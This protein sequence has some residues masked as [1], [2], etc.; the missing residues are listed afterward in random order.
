M[1]ACGQQDA[2][3]CYA[4]LHARWRFWIYVQHFDHDT[5]HCPLV[6]CRCTRGNEKHLHSHL[7]EGF[8]GNWSI[9]ECRHMCFGQ[10]F[11]WVNDCYAIKFSRSYDGHNPSILRLQMQF[12]CWEMGIEHRNDHF[13]TNAI[14]WSRLGAN[15]TFDPLLREYIKQ[16]Q[17]LQIHNPSPTSLLPAPENMPY[18]RGPRLP[19]MLPPPTTNDLGEASVD[20]SAYTAHASASSREPFLGLQH[21]SNVLVCFF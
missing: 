3:F 4:P 16:V 10:R 14:Y 19:A 17:A 2:A 18:V 20:Y 9:N 11:L 7:G 21:L 12:M 8:S 5:L 1:S 6:G 13:L 15:L